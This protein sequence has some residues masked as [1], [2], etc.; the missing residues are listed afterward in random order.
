MSMPGEVHIVYYCKY[1]Q[2]LNKSP[3][4]KEATFIFFS[5]Y[6]LFTSNNLYKISFAQDKAPL[7][8]IEKHSESTDDKGKGNIMVSYQVRIA[9]E[10]LIVQ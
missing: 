7:Q 1:I 5:R 10:I 3:L 4:F 2:L 8:A 9:L 6:K